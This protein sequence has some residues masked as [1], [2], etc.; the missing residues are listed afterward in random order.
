M[1]AITLE[2]P[3]KDPQDSTREYVYHM[4]RTNILNL[5]YEP[6]SVLSENEIADM[7]NIS[8]TPI[9]EAILR[10]AQERLVDIFPQKGTY[11]SL[12]DLRHVA[13]SRFMRVTLEREVIIQAC[14]SFPEDAFFKLQTSLTLQELCIQEKRWAEFYIHDRNMHGAIFAGC[15]KELTWEMIQQMS[16][17]DNR[18]KILNISTGYDLPELLVQHKTIVRAIK[19]KNADLGI[20]TIH[21]HL[22]KVRQ[23]IKPLLNDF[24]NWFV[25]K[26]CADLTF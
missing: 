21:A 10:L 8:R 2:I 20:K 26:E 23:D 17:H 7:L 12:I 16:T 19:E 6:G 13:E 24:P 3:K 25:Q 18:V 15:D 9:R 22:T 5:N 11:V 1:I 4:L 14:V